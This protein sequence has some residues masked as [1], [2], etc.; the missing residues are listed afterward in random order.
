MAH[1]RQQ[2]YACAPR[3]AEISDGR[4][5]SRR[6]KSRNRG[7]GRCPSSAEATVAIELSTALSVA[8]GDPVSC[9]ATGAAEAVALDEGLEQ[10]ASSAMQVDQEDGQILRPFAHALGR[11]VPASGISRSKCWT[12]EVKTLCRGPTYRSLQCL[13]KVMIPVVS[14]LASDS[15][16]A[17]DCSRA[18]PRPA[19]GT[20]V[21]LAPRLVS[22]QLAP[23]VHLAWQAAL[24]PERLIRSKTMPAS[25]M[26]SPDSPHRL[27]QPD[28]PGRL[29]QGPDQL[30]RTRAA[31]RHTSARRWR[32]AATE[33][34]HRGADVRCSALLMISSADL[35]YSGEG[36]APNSAPISCSP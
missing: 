10:G 14:E 34:L 26:P 32:E 18:D 30:L 27:D 15:V 13:A 24:A 19:R 22:E 20:T 7:R 28:E 12:W 31:A 25:S 35:L 29:G 33:L 5:A 1:I 17:N 21:V 4:V 36:P 11:V 9:T 6:R 8:D 23:R 2:P 16:T 3:V